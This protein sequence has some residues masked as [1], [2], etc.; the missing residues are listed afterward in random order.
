MNWERDQRSE[1]VTAL[2]RRFLASPLTGKVLAGRLAG[3]SGVKICPLLLHCVPCRSWSRENIRS[4]SPVIRFGVIELDLRSRELYKQG[5]KIP[6]QGSITIGP[7]PSE[8]AFLNTE[9][10]RNLF[11]IPLH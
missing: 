3:R 11:R 5:M 1:A 6:L 7:N 2:K 4:P 9:L 10:Q 8:D